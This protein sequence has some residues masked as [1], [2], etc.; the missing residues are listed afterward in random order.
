MF[1]GTAAK[2]AGD[3]FKKKIGAPVK[4][5]SLEFEK[6]FATLKA[7]DPKN[8]Q[9]VDEYKYVK[10]FVAGPTPVKLSSLEAISDGTLFD[11]DQVDLGATESLAKAAVERTK[12]EG[13]NV[14]KMVIERGLSIGNSVAKSGTVRWTVE[15][16]GPRESATATADVKGRI[17]GLDLS[18]T[19]RAASYSA[20]SPEVLRDA[21]PAI[22]GAL[23]GKVRL[24]ELSINDKY[25]WFKAMS[26]GNASEL[27]QYKYDINGVTTS[28]L[29]NLTDPTPIKVRMSPKNKLED[30]LFDLDAVKLEMAPELGQKALARLGFSSGK[31]ELYKVSRE[32]R[33]FW[34]ADLE[35]R[36]DVS[37]KQGRKTGSVTYDL[38]GNELKVS[39][40]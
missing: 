11:L 25:I 38:T 1:E 37:C 29:S 10:G 27:T 9:N 35:T 7:Q 5:L 20:F 31:V 4:A 39:Q 19:A 34:K 32:Q 40:R 36:W 16:E 33:D 8:P 12:I 2:D 24:M 13:G 23:G 21:G 28:Q 22:K 14:K 6:D 30:F 26:P 15:V 18:Q 17:L 3:A